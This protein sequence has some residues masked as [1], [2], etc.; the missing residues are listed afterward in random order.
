MMGAWN[1]LNGN[2]IS[3]ELALLIYTTDVRGGNNE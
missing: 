3:T 1:T 2:P